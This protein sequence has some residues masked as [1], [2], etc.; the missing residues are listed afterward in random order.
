VCLHN[1]IRKF[2]VVVSE[3]V[4]RDAHLLVRFAM[5]VDKAVLEILEKEGNKGYGDIK[6]EDT[7]V[8][9]AEQGA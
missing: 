7:P 8:I 4:P 1:T 2:I 5:K 9:D 6:D 3:E